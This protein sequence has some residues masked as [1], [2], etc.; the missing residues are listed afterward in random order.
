MVVA[1]IVAMHGVDL[2]RPSADHQEA[3]A[4]RQMVGGGPVDRRVQPPTLAGVHAAYTRIKSELKTSSLNLVVLKR[5][6][7]AY[8]RY[9][10]NERKLSTSGSKSPAAALLGIHSALQPLKSVLKTSSL[11]CVGSRRYRCALNRCEC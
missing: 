2:E 5:Y 8:T 1:L 9:D 7:Y 4:R 6:K 10:C 3:G 11:T